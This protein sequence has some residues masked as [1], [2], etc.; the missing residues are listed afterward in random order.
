MIEILNFRFTDA[1]RL[2]TTLTVE[3][4]TSALGDGRERILSKLTA[5]PLPV[6]LRTLIRR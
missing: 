5:S 2:F 3:C 4:E 1:W 6:G